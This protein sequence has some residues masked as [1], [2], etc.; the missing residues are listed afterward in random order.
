MGHIISRC[1]KN[2][3]SFYQLIYLSGKDYRILLERWLDNFQDISYFI[4][5]N[6]W[7][8]YPILY[9]CIGTFLNVIIN[10]CISNKFIWFDYKISYYFVPIFVDMKWSKFNN[11]I[12]IRY[13][14]YLR[15]YI[16]VTLFFC[17]NPRSRNVR[18]RTQ[19][20]SSTCTL[21]MVVIRKIYN[22][23]FT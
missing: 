23:D 3:T 13:V 21:I 7:L 9:I 8:T 4:Q 19:F 1:C 6:K 12:N 17:F 5:M 18:K 22:S 11:T 10:L 20:A 16:K 14:L 2:K 15:F